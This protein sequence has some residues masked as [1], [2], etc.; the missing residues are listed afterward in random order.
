MAKRRTRDAAEAIRWT[1]GRCELGWVL[2]ARSSRGVCAILLGD[3]RDA[4]EREARERFP[5]GRPIDTDVE[6][7]GALR[8]AIALVERPSGRLG[9]DLDARGTPF[10]RRVWRALREVPP[11]TTIT[12]AAL[13]SRVGSARSARAVGAACAANPLAVAVPCHRVVRGDGSLSGYRWGLERKA[14]LLRREADAA[15]VETEPAA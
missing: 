1:A 10:Q 4:V 12:Y 2:V 9:R 7:R 13:A 5:G 11:G 3:S 6:T 14:E 8:A 15:R